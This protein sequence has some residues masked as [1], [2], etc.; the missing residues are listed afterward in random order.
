M[1]CR[2]LLFPFVGHAKSNKLKLNIK[3]YLLFGVQ[4]HIASK[5]FF[6][7]I[8]DINNWPKKYQISI[9][10]YLTKTTLAPCESQHA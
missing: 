6:I 10:I 5:T 3:N 7:S 9:D 1:M 8:L 2:K 4:Q